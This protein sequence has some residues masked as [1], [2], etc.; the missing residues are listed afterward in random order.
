MGMG[1]PDDEENDGVISMMSATAA[2]AVLRGLPLMGV[3]CAPGVWAQDA[4]HLLF[5][6]GQA[7]GRGPGFVVG[8][9][10]ENDTRIPVREGYVVV[11][12]LDE[13]CYPGRPV[14]QTFGPLAPG[15]KAG[16]SVPVNGDVGG[17][18]L[19]SVMAL[20]DMG[21]PLAVVDDTASVIAGREPAERK[22]CLKTR[23]P[24]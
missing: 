8:G 17:Y 18:R 7:V 21:Y 15:E 23:R 11:V 10:L 1:M 2:K 6:V 5:H 3:L 14:L 22:A 19:V 20:D 4:V 9:T 13:R 24:V 12:P 16:F